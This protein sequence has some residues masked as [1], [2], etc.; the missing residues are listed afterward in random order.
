[1]VDH[2]KKDIGVLA[3]HRFLEREDFEPV[4]RDPN[5]ED[6]LAANA[7]VSFKLEGDTQLICQREAVRNAFEGEF[8]TAETFGEAVR[9]V[10]EHLPISLG[11]LRRKS[12]MAAGIQADL[13]AFGAGSRGPD[14]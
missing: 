9:G 12:T 1:L 13:S 6:A 11:R 7:N 14:E 8:G 4:F 2:T 5:W 3:V 10:A